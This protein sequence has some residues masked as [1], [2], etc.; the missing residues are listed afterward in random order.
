MRAETQDGKPVLWEQLE[1][2]FGAGVRTR[3]GRGMRGRDRGS[4]REAVGQ[5][6]GVG[7]PRASPGRGWPQPFKSP[8]LGQARSS[9]QSVL[10]PFSGRLCT[11]ACGGGWGHGRMGEHSSEVR[12]S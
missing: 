11:R 6:F 1:C 8:S 5:G 3:R 12:P 9:P 2:G 10:M 7:L 4:G